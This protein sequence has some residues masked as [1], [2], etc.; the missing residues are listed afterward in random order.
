MGTI[1]NWMFHDDV[2]LAAL[3]RMLIDRKLLKVRFQATAFDA[4]YVE[5][6][7]LEASR[8]LGVSF[9]DAGYF[10]F[11]GE[12]VN[13]TYNSSDEKIN[14]LFKDGSVKDISHV[15]NA[16]VQQTLAST[17]KKFYICHLNNTL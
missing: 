2:V 14:I 15:D 1:K 16:L 7:R 11:T 13:T 4:S 12:V 9:A 3:S 8:L 17:V 6:L 5:Q 10:V